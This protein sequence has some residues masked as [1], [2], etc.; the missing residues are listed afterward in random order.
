MVI[1]MKNKT[2]L[3]IIYC[4]FLSIIFII[5][6]IRWLDLFGICLLVGTT[7]ALS[8]YEIKSKDKTPLK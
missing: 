7:L 8:W 1:K 6:E 5:S 2:K 4:Y 3:F